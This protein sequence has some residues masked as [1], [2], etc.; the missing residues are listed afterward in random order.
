[1]VYRGDMQVLSEQPYA[2]RRLVL[3]RNTRPEGY[4]GSDKKREITEEVI[5]YLYPAQ[6]AQIK[7]VGQHFHLDCIDGLPW[8][9]RH[10]S[11]KS[12]NVWLNVRL[13]QILEISQIS[14]L[15]VVKIAHVCCQ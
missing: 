15:P 13:L 12:P 6:I 3:Q 14:S 8:L 11:P 5:D 9:L 7:L 10:A 1:M 4:E 2:F